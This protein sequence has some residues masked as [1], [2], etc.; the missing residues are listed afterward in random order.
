MDYFHI[1]LPIYQRYFIMLKTYAFVNSDA[2][3]IILLK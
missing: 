1:N 3:S 2:K